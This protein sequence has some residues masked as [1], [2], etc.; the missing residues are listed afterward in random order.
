MLLWLDSLNQDFDSVIQVRKLKGNTRSIL[1]IGLQPSSEIPA[2]SQLT[3]LHPPL[4]IETVALPLLATLQ[5]PD[6]DVQ[7]AAAKALIGAVSVSPYLSISL[8][9]LMMAQLRIGKA[10]VQH[11]ILNVL[12]A[13]SLDTQV[14]PFANR[15][16]GP[17]QQA[18]SHPVLSCLALKL[19]VDS[20]TLSGKNWPK[21]EV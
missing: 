1:D 19:V 10:R 12:P 4:D 8:L 18:R 5:H 21:V 14:A 3:E 6:Q 9:P 7:V 16:L 17:M 15:V 11:E 2:L 13:M 20:W